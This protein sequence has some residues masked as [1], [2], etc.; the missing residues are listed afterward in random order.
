MWA[1]DHPHGCGEKAGDEI[2]SRYSS[3]SSPRVW[4]KAPSLFALFLQPRIIPTGVGKSQTFRPEWLSE[5]DHPHG[6][7]E[8]RISFLGI[9]FS[10]GS[11]P[12]VWGKGFCCPQQR[13]GERI[14]PTG[15]GKRNRW[16]EK[17]V[18]HTDHPHG[19]GEKSQCELMRLPDPGSSPRVWGKAYP[20]E[21]V[22]PRARIIPTGVGKSQ[23]FRPAW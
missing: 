4:G 1:S 16:D 7:G 21:T 13:V 12:R 3:G 9:Y 19:C 20:T 11:S 2:V 5:A 15:V 22:K 14:I 17:S 6:C 8:K 18:S 23:T 10:I